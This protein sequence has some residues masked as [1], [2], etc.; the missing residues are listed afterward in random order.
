MWTHLERQKGG[1]GMRGPGETQIETDRRI[2]GQKISLLKKQLEK[3][4]KQK[5]TQRKGRGNMIRLVLVGYTN[6]GKSTLM[7]Q[8]SKSEVFA[9]NKLFATL[10]TTI[11]KVVVENLPFL[12]ADT[13][14]FIRKLPHQLVESFK[15]TLDEVRESDLLLH[16]VD[17]SNPNFENQIEVVTQTLAEIGASDKPIILL[18]NKT[19]AFTFVEKEEDDLTPKTKENF[20]LEELQKTWI[21]KME[22]N[23]IFISALKKTNF[24]QLRK[25]LYEK[26]KA[27]HIKRYPYNNYL[28]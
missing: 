6:S 17:I 15:S 27:L 5:I 20:S 14:G 11:R 19:D 26:I 18:F 22:E 24:E 10:D 1:I 8:L 21:A 4:D 16:V 2:I 12:L 23:T 7:N 9:E 28:Y 3:I 13:V 25:L